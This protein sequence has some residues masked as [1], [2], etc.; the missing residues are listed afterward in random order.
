M[1]DFDLLTTEQAAE[2]LG[3][4]RRLVQLW[5]KRGTLPS[6]TTAIRSGGGF[7]RLIKA[8]DLVGFEKPRRGRPPKTAQAAGDGGQEVTP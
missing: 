4:S 1:K 2:R 3:V 7:V 6:L 8:E 5:V